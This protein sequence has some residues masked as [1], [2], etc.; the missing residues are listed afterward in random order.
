M[1][2]FIDFKWQLSLI[3]SLGV[4]TLLS[5]TTFLTFFV[6]ADN[7]NPGLYSKDSKPFGISYGDRLAN[8]SVVYPVPCG[9]T[10]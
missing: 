4:M 3:I 5:S 7:L 9:F 2:H 10:S 1:K 8:Y 6:N